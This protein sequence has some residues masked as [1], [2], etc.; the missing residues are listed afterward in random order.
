MCDW[1]DGLR[2]NCPLFVSGSNK[3]AVRERA[4]ASF[5]VEHIKVF[6]TKHKSAVKLQIIE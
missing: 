4:K 2:Q 1:K 3:L 5:L 6:F